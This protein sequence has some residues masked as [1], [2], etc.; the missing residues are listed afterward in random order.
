MQTNIGPM[1]F[2]AYS[3]GKIFARWF[4]RLSDFYYFF[5]FYVIH[6]NRLSFCF[7]NLMDLFKAYNHFSYLL[8]K[9]LKINKYLFPGLT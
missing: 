4:N 9:K 1:S 7:G 2:T 3:Q 6:L 5:S 8:I